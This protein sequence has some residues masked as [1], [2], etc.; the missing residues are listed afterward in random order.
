MIK[1]FTTILVSLCTF[2][3]FAHELE[4][5]LLHIYARNDSEYLEKRSLP[6]HAEDWLWLRNRG[7]LLLGVPRPDNPPMDITLRAN[8]YEGVTADIAG[9]LSHLLHVEIVVKTYPLAR[10][11]LMRSRG[12]RSTC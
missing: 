12:K 4:T 9:M 6:L 8:A 2:C 10:R 7:R 1:L 5:E 11:P 3:S